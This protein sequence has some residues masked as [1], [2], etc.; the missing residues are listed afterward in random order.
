MLRCLNLLRLECVFAIDIDNLILSTGWD[1]CRPITVGKRIT[2]D[3]TP[4]GQIDVEQHGTTLGTVWTPHLTLLTNLHKVNTFFVRLDH[5]AIITLVNCYGGATGFLIGFA[6][7]AV[8]PLLGF[9]RF[10][11]GDT[12][13]TLTVEDDAGCGIEFGFEGAAFAFHGEVVRHGDDDDMSV[14]L[15]VQTA[16][17]C[18]C[19]MLRSWSSTKASWQLAELQK[20]TYVGRIYYEFP[21]TEY[22]YVVIVSFDKTYYIRAVK[23]CDLHFI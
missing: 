16:P 3:G 18:E 17:S 4:I 20:G 11:N 1:I 19:F 12:G 7:D 15:T 14:V 9:D 6:G 10:A 2:I 8:E 23:R 22:C 5:S 13:V 21:L